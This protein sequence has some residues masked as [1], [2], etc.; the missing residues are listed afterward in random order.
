MW[1]EAFNQYHLQ[2]EDIYNYDESPVRLGHSST[3]K[4]ITRTRNKKMTSGKILNRESATV[5]DCISADG[6]KLPALIILQGE[7]VQE[8]WLQARIPNN[9]ILAVTESAYVNDEIFWEWIHH[10]DHYTKKRQKGVYRLLL[11]DGHTSHLT[12]E[13]LQ[14]YNEQKILLFLLLPYLTHLIQLLDVACFQPFKHYYA[15][16]VDQA[17]F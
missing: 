14:F 1:K 2:I 10:F 9:Y 8:R 11:F 16:A 12:I 17:F 7:T 13:V 4:T 6:W 5:G 15:R 3:T